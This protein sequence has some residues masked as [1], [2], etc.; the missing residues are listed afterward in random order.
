MAKR[1][2]LNKTHKIRGQDVDVEAAELDGG[3]PGFE[4]V[5]RVGTTEIREGHFIGAADGKGAA[6]LDAAEEQAKLDAHRQELAE[7]AERMERAKQ[8]GSSLI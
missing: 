8:I 2:L 1:V 7:R 4:L 6:N 5:A 3:V